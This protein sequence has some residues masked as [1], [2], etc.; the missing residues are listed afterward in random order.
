MTYDNDG[1]FV[2]A[3]YATA[4]GFAFVL[5]EGPENPIDWGAKELRGRRKNN[6]TLDE[7]EKLIDRYR[8]DALVIED[9]S[10]K[11][12]RRSSRIRR[13][14]R[15]LGHLAAT[16][17]VDLYR[18]SRNVVRGT[19]APTGAVTKVE[20]AEAIARQIPALGHR[21]PR[22]RKIWMSE[23]PRQSLFD[24]AALA[25]T[26]FARPPSGSIPPVD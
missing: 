24:A 15:A 3:V 16:E 8:P 1:A 17:Y 12:S 23:D 19:F 25:L 14:Y 7:V 13:L 4:R 22:E 20:I 2:L 6:R 9:I 18:Y 5:F 26:H 11:G 10:E 21:L